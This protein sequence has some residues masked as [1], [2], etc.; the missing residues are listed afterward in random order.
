LPGSAGLDGRKGVKGDTPDARDRPGIP[1]RLIPLILL[2]C[3]LTALIP[4]K[5]NKG[6]YVSKRHGIACK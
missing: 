2:L 3:T 4:D 6:K 1:G 5:H